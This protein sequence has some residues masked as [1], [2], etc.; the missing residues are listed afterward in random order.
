VLGRGRVAAL[1]GVG[2]EHLG[3]LPRWQGSDLVGG[4]LGAEEVRDL[5]NHPARGLGR[6]F[7]LE[8]RPDPVA[9]LLLGT[10][11]RAGVL[12]WLG[13]QVVRTFTF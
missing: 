8:E 2:L 6:P 10:L 12:L 3:G 1:V 4:G 7:M 13:G 9:D 11:D 5:A